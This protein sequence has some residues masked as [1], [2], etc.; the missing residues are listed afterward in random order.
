MAAEIGVELVL[1]AEL[2]LDDEVAA[3]EHGLVDALLR[4]L[5]LLH[6]DPDVARDALVLVRGPRSR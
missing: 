5:A 3:S 4:D 1:S 2:A 6:R